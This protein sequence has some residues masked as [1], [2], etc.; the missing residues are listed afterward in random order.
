MSKFCYAIKKIII[1]STKADEFRTT[2]MF[3]RELGD[4]VIKACSNILRVPIM[5]ITSSNSVPCVLVC[6]FF[7]ED[8]LSNDSIYVAY[9]YVLWSWAL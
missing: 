3:N 8:S 9:H 4:V 6:F 2:G 5:V 1:I 7:P